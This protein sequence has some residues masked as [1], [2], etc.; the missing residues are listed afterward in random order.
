MQASMANGKGGEILALTRI[1]EEKALTRSGQGHG[2]DSHLQARDRLTGYEGRII[3]LSD[4]I[5]FVLVVVVL[6]RD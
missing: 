4:D 6:P 2:A 3:L 5:C 1:R